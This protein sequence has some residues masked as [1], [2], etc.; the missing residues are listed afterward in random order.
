MRTA[1][2]AE[3]DAVLKGLWPDAPWATLRAAL[4]P[5][6]EV[7]ITHRAHR[8]GLGRKTREDTPEHVV[9][10]RDRAATGNLRR[11]TGT[12]ITSVDG[13][14]GKVCNKCS[15][16]KPLTKFC[17]KTDCTG[18]RRN[19][20]TTCEG[21]LQYANHR[22]KCIDQAR[23]YQLR[24]PDKAKII[25]A[26]SRIRRLEW[27]KTGKITASEWRQC[28]IAH[29]FR[30]VYCGSDEKIEMD[31]VIPLSRGG[32]NRIENIAPACRRCNLSK[33]DKT[34]DEWRAHQQKVS[35]KCHF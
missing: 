1:W 7:A 28:L 6:T 33:H 20:C 27:L 13:Q 29:N 8:I 35:A 16:W 9:W 30:C 17:R 10:L 31:H 18:G 23:K 22:L 32:P 14:D 24:H 12:P 3:R 21:R 25:R 19:I 11:G 4:A 26:A 15:A 2:T 34:P 5:S